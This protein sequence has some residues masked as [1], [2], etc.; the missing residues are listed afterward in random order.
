MK[1]FLDQIEEGMLIERDI[2]SNNGQVIIPKNTL[3]TAP[4]IEKLRNFEIDYIEIGKNEPEPEPESEPVAEH[5]I[6]PDEHI[7]DPGNIFDITSTE[8]FNEFKHDCLENQKSLSRA[9]DAILNSTNNQQ[10]SAFVGLVKK[11]GADLNL[12]NMQ[13]LNLL[14]MIYG[15]RDISDVVYIH[16]LNVG[17]IAGTMGKWLEMSEDDI[18]T[19]IMC[20]LFHD[21]GKLLVPKDILE[22]NGPLTPLEYAVM[23]THSTKGY[24][25]LEKFDNL[26][27]RIKQT[28]LNHH[29]RCDGSGYPRQ[30]KNDQ[31]DVFS[32]IIAI[33]DV[34]DAMTSQRVYRKP[35]CPFAVAA[36]FEKEG[37]HKFDTEY[38][39]LFLHNMLNTYLQSKVRLSNGQ[40]GRVI[41]IHRHHKSKPLVELEDG[42]FIDLAKDHSVSIT[43][44]I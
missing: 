43:E 36:E 23:Q 44:M 30:L 38:I 34:Y 35:I 16:S 3:I 14:D 15:M 24:E 13:S 37:L 9:F 21:I 19:L 31:I 12:S 4:L 18:Q 27:D 26:D 2:V 1:I 25:L 11:L 17:M 10:S 22:K 41:K 39:L 6:E 40:V 20:G 42:T 29:E 32:K 28:A 7:S 5:S 8:K 33:A